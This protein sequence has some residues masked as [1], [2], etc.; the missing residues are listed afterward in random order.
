MPPGSFLVRGAPFCGVEAPRGGAGL[1]GA[2]G[3][4]FCGVEAPRGGAGLLGAGGAPFCG[5]EAPFGG[6]P[7]CGAEAPWG[8]AGLLGA[9]GAPFCGVEAP[10][11]RPRRGLFVFIVFLVGV[12]ALG[13]QQIDPQIPGGD[14]D[15]R[16][17]EGRG[18]ADS[19]NPPGSADS[20]DQPGTPDPA[21]PPESVNQTNLPGSADSTDQTGQS[22]SANQINQNQ[23]NQSQSDDQKNQKNQ[24]NHINQSNKSEL[25]LEELLAEALGHAE[26]GEWERALELL[27]EAE[28][29]APDDARIESYRASVKELRAVDAAQN[30]WVEGES[31]EVEREETEEV[32]QEAKFVIERE[33]DRDGEDSA[34]GRDR[35]HADIAVKLFVLDPI[36][37]DMVNSW[38]SAD[39]F[40]YSSVNV[41][42]RYWLPFG[43]RI[44]GFYFAS[45]GFS[46]PPARPT[47]LVNTLNLG[48]GFRGFLLESPTSR[49]ELGIDFGAALYS[50]KTPASGEIRRRIPLF[51]GLTISDPL[52]YH[53]FKVGS[54]ENL[55]FGA[56]IRFYTAARGG[57][58]E[59]GEQFIEN[60]N[61]R[62]DASWRFGGGAEA[63]IRLEWWDFPVSGVRRSPLSIALFGGFRY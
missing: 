39:E 53:L 43:R 7:F 52:L 49:L 32:E 26:R 62:V 45:N 42:L 44:F 30:A 59:Q 37:R 9:G 23:S 24:S 1:L 29:L 34:G 41:N 33:E 5:G 14:K 38:S 50:E 35:L 8:G 19:A 16:T 31:V 17:S 28:R 63:G 20:V 21:N 2:G 3:A 48:V 55:V 51:L 36:D 4:P 12:G 46:W 40:F 13:G 56:G 18:P 58:G 15:S 60:L 61:Y 6:A 25:G 10:W 54:M 27:D 47:L 22:G 57:Q 11:G